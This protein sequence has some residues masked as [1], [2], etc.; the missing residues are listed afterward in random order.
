MNLDELRGVAMAAAEREDRSA[1]LSALRAL[2]AALERAGEDAEALQIHEQVIQLDPSD[3]AALGALG[4]Q[5]P[6]PL[7]DTARNAPRRSEA[8]DREISMAGPVEPSMTA[9]ESLYELGVAYTEME[10]WTEALARFEEVWTQVPGHLPTARTLLRLFTP[11]GGA[12]CTD[13]WPEDERLRI[14]YLLGRSQEVL[15]NSASAREFYEETLSAD[16]T[17]QDAA[18][19]LRDLGR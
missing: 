9:A 14:R 13:G 1:L 3:S 19:R 2:A 17:F 11:V 12:V 15:G 7:I 5:A 10:L 18:E 6:P 4:R 8:A 16:P